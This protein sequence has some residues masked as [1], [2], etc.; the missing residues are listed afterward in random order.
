MIKWILTFIILWFIYQV[1]D[2]FPPIIVG[3]I[4]AYLLLPLVQH[5]AASA[6]IPI[7]VA[8]AIVYLIAATVLGLTAWWLVPHIVKEIADLASHRDEIIQNVVQ[9]LAGIAHWSGDPADLQRQI[10]DGLSGLPAAAELPHAVGEVSHGALNVLVCV[11][12]SIYFTLDSG[13]IGRFFLRYMPSE[14]AN[15]AVALTGQMNRL[16]SK[17]VQ[18]QLILIALMASVAWIFLHFALHMRY[19]L[20]VAILCGFLEIIPVLGPI[21]AI[22]TAVL[23]GIWQFGASS[24]F[25]IIGFFTIARWVED[26][27][28][29]PKIIGHAVELHPLAVI[30]AVLCGEHLA[31]A[32]GMLIAIPVAACIKLFIDF[33]YFGRQ[34]E[35]QLQTGVH[36]EWDTEAQHSEHEAAQ[37]VPVVEVVAKPTMDSNVASIRPHA[38][39]IISGKVPPPEGGSAATKSEAESSVVVSRSDER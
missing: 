5:L 4:I 11:V 26:Y 18:G 22:S 35:G 15:Q 19:A 29:V 14:R 30:F 10:M 2:V 8:T 7:G 13:S 3:G 36:P 31:G 38:S 34:P 37:A 1:R 32:L 21:L 39:T 12:S 20:P 28:V 16:I 24:S 17:Y 23:V 6:K 9:Q 25:V 27:V 33:F